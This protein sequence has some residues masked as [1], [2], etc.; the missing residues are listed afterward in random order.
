MADFRI[1]TGNT[2]DESV[3]LTAQCKEVTVQK[4]Q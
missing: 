3:A 4:E 2:Q 1:R